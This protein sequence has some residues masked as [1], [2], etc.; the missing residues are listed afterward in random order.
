MMHNSN[1]YSSPKTTSTQP[2]ITTENDKNDLVLEVLLIGISVLYLYR[3]K[4]VSLFY[5][6]CNY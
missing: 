1:V 5:N 6:T 2:P 3:I 4:K